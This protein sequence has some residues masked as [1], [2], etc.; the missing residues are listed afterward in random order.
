MKDVWITMYGSKQLTKVQLKWQAAERSKMTLQYYRKRYMHHMLPVLPIRH[1]SVLGCRWLRRLYSLSQRVR[2]IKLGGGITAILENARV[3]DADHRLLQLLKVHSK[4]IVALWH[5]LCWYT[6][7]L[8]WCKQI[9]VFNDQH[10]RAWC[11]RS[12]AVSIY[13]LV[14]F[15]VNLTDVQRKSPFESM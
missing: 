2:L 8:P 11:S 7:D 13:F 9:T 3:C 5:I 12:P 4:C 6:R 15:R 14:E 1:L 10:T